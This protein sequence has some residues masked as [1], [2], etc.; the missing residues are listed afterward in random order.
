MLKIKLTGPNGFERVFERDATPCEITIGRAP[1]S[2]IVIDDRHV[3][4][5]HVRILTGLVVIDE[6]STNGT[7]VSGKKIPEGSA[8]LVQDGHFTLGTAIDVEVREEAEEDDE[9]DE[10]GLER[11]LPDAG[12]RTA[13][14][15]VRTDSVATEELVELRRDNDELEAENEDLRRRIERL[16]HEIEDRERAEADS[17]QMRACYQELA[18]VRSKNEQLHGEVESLRKQKDRG[19]VEAAKAVLEESVAR[20]ESERADLRAETQR[21]RGEL[22]E[23]R[24]GQRSTPASEVLARYE[25][26]IGQLEGELESL[27]KSGGPSG[28]ETFADLRSEIAQLETEN[29]RLLRAVEERAADETADVSVEDLGDE[30]RRER[31]SKADL[32]AELE[33]LR[34]EVERQRSSRPAGSGAPSARQGGDPLQLLADASRHDVDALKAD[35]SRDL[36]EFITLELFRFVRSSERLITRIAGDVWGIYDPGTIAIL[37]EGEKTLLELTADLIHAPGDDGLEPHEELEMRHE[38]VAH[39]GELSRWL[40]IGTTVYPQAAERFALDLRS[41]LSKD[42]LT[43]GNP[44][45]KMMRMGGREGAELW[46]RAQSVLGEMSVDTVRDRVQRTAHALAQEMSERFEGETR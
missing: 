25:M 19:D 16:K 40:V 28:A 11:T 44:I 14:A 46:E 9:F 4:G 22:E 27:R 17:P 13:S 31:S 8:T 23:A 24:E 6:A 42:G 29:A 5:R 36:A 37:P 38:F 10:G 39:L 18:D 20:L 30:L 7:F 43:A 26:R 33:R 41:S 2:D 21:L 35:T 12:G 32:V 45:P 34:I 15:A 3:S 1:T